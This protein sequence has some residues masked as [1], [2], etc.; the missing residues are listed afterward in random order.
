MQ[1]CVDIRAHL[2]ASTETFEQLAQSGVIGRELAPKLKKAMGF[3]NIAMHHYDAINSI[4]VHR[5]V[6]NQLTDFFVF[7]K[8]AARTL[9]EN[10]LP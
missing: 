10:E 3:R 7:A 2:I 5:I 9:D 4:M 6:K 8:A 1:L